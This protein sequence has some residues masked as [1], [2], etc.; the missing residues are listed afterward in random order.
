MDALTSLYL[1]FL[2]CKIG[3]MIVP[4]PSKAAVRRLAE[5]I[6]VQA[7]TSACPMCTSVGMLESDCGRQ[8]GVG[9]WPGT[10]IRGVGD[11]LL[12]L[13]LS[14]W[15]IQIQASVEVKRWNFP[16]CMPVVTAISSRAGDTRRE[17]G[18]CL[19]VF[20]SA[21]PPRRAQCLAHILIHI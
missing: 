13:N 21:R 12:P 20:L 5:L 9:S 19:P 3:I 6:Y 1:S 15:T 16:V 7:E 8:D 2:N 4:A 11:L 10:I 14:A 18:V 17:V